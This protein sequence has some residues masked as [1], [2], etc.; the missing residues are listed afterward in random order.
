MLIPFTAGLMSIISPCVLIMI[1]ALVFSMSK[2]GISKKN[3]WTYVLFLCIFIAF[4][5][6]IFGMILNDKWQSGSFNEAN[7]PGVIFELGYLVPVINFLFAIW[8]TGL[9]DKTL[10]KIEKGIIFK[11]V[12][13]LTIAVVFTSV[14]FN[15]TCGLLSG[16]L[17]IPVGI[18]GP[19]SAAKVILFFSLGLVIPVILILVLSVRLI[20]RVN[21]NK[22]WNIWQII[23]AVLLIIVTIYVL[24]FRTDDS[25]ASQVKQDN[26]SPSHLNLNQEYGMGQQAESDYNAVFFGFY[27]LT[28][29]DNALEKAFNE[30][31][32][33]LLY[34]TGHGCING[35]E[36]EVNILSDPEIMKR[37][38]NEYLPYVGFVDDKTPL[39]EN[40]QYNSKST[41]KTI[42]TIGQRVHDIQ[43]THFT[44]A[45]PYFV[46][47]DK[48]GNVI[49]KTGYLTDIKEF[50]D[51]LDKGKIDKN[52]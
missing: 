24:F 38:L 12:V 4:F 2:I 51:F 3:K 20:E 8:L 11:F 42:K 37:I 23:T 9:F 21:I 49:S 47:I 18:S 40:Q 26:S 25:N 28:D 45:Q 14:S 46:L 16:L 36:M 34:F 43:L 15:C 31:K 30:N 6:L 32:P 27:D 7:Y 41:G 19:F 17:V 48:N 39:P 1:P 44:N 29:Y 22:W 50:S 10:C 52:Q 5:Y 35:R 33:V 13:I